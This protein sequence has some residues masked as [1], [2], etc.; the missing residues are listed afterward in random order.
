MKILVLG[1]S[2]M[3]GDAIYQRL[4]L[5]YDT[6]GTYCNHIPNVSVPRYVH[7]SVSD[8]N[9]FSAILQ[10]IK[11]SVV[12]SSLRGDFA[13]QESRH[14]ELAKYLSKT[15]GRLIFLS[16]ANVF[17]GCPFEP[18]SERD[19]PYPASGYGQFKYHCEQVLKEILG[20][21]LTI[22]R[23]PKVLN[24]I[25]L[26]KQIA[27]S[28]KNLEVPLYTN[29]FIS[30]NTAENVAKEVRF[31]I[32][33]E[34]F[35]IFHLTSRDFIPHSVF[36]ERLFAK[37]GRTDMKCRKVMMSTEEYC[38]ELGGVSDKGGKIILALASAPNVLPDEFSLG[39][40]EIVDLLCS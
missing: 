11:P 36:Y 9:E 17:D 27:E 15:G 32:K 30:F 40:L 12:V 1:A 8:S 16:T 25:R 13:E 34:L 20:D 4:S 14:K 5:D 21:H 6:Y 29:L 10:T 31:I 37:I 24:K 19:V 22:V 18:H 2:G 23:L 28:P 35:G 38:V 26:Q 7:F 39:C 3:I 33:H